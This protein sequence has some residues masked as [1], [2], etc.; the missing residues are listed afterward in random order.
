[1]ADLYNA[2]ELKYGYCKNECPIGRMMPLAT[3]E[4]SIEGIALRIVREFDYKGLRTMKET[5]IEIAAD[6]KVT[7]DEKE[8]L[9]TVLSKLDEIALVI[10]EMKIAGEKILKG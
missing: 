9:M 6:G 10:S 2:P 8:G 4:S 1:M 5:L 3:E 7:E